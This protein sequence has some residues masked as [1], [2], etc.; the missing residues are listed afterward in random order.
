[1]IL[2]RTKSNSHFII[3][4]GIGLIGNTMIKEFKRFNILI[5]DYCKVDWGNKLFFTDIFLNWIN[6][7]SIKT[8]NKLSFVWS[9]GKSGFNSD[10]ADCLLENCHFESFLNSIKIFS[11]THKFDVTIHLISSAG[12]L[13][14]GQLG[15]NSL[16]MPNPKRPYGF[17]KLW[18]EQ[19]LSSKFPNSH[20]V[21]RPSSVYGPIQNGRRLGLVSKMVKSIYQNSEITIFGGM[22]TLR[23]FIWVD[24][25]AK[26]IVENILMDL[27]NQTRVM[28]L[29]SAKPTSILEVTILISK[30]TG[31]KVLFKFDNKID[32]SSMSFSN[33]VKPKSTT[34]LQLG[35]KL[36]TFNS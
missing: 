21:Y 26:S 15:V 31:K 30:I 36:I 9:A 32:F 22:S 29:V 19:L 7:R 35:I 25:V 2:L 13:F 17:S 27:D 28:F 33:H 34:N 24:D 12:G 14:E 18:Q 16:S 8:I 10:E 20:V 4:V 1:M 23:D 3:M 5:V 6:E 11:S